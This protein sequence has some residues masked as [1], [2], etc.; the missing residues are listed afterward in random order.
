VLFKKGLLPAR[1]ARGNSGAFQE[2][3]VV[4]DYSNKIRLFERAGCP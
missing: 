1:P 3:V 4:T 2:P